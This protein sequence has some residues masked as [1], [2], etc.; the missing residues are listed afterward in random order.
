MVCVVALNAGHFAL[1]DMVYNF[2]QVE[3]STSRVLRFPVET[4]VWFFG[5][6]C[7]C[8]CQGCSAV[9]E[10]KQGQDT[11]KTECAEKRSLYWFWDTDEYLELYAWVIHTLCKDAHE[12]SNL[13]QNHDWSILTQDNPSQ[14]I[15]CFLKGDLSAT[16]WSNAQ[17]DCAMHW[18]LQFES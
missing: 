4:L 17:T 1:W 7:V 10:I 3:T 6:I 16:K 12:Y 13:S 15:V 18:V 8:A 2:R 11:S 5:F 14:G 9:W